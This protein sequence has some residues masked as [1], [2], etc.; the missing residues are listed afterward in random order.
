MI[1]ILASYIWALIALVAAFGLAT[2]ALAL[3]FPSNGRGRV[4]TGILV[5]VLVASTA[6]LG[7][8]VLS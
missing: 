4:E 2:S 3:A 5:A 6:T 7:W 8:I 1:L